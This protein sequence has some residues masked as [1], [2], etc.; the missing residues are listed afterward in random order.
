MTCLRVSSQ[1]FPAELSWMFLGLVWM[2]NNAFKDRY[3]T[4][5]RCLARQNV[6]SLSLKEDHDSFFGKTRAKKT[7]K[8]V[9]YVMCVYTAK[10]HNLFNCLKIPQTAITLVHKGQKT[11]KQSMNCCQHRLSNI[12]SDLHKSEPAQLV[13]IST[14]IL[15]KRSVIPSSSYFWQ[16][17]DYLQNVTWGHPLCLHWQIVPIMCKQKCQHA[18]DG[19]VC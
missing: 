14:N 3:T 13:T 8:T 5:I 18:K 6:K 9:S 15:D 1:R 2:S 4:E 12:N 17:L 16:N 10:E 19:E 7:Q 11:K